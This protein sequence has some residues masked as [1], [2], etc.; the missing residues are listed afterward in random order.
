MR[1]LFFLLDGSAEGWEPEVHFYAPLCWY[2]RLTSLIHNPT[3]WVPYK[4]HL[5]VYTSVETMYE[6]ICINSIAV[7]YLDNLY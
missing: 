3:K 6:G 4:W 5:V 7:Q 1:H 2:N